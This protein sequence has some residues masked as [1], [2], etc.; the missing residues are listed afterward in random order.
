MNRAR[1][2]WSGLN[3]ILGVNR[4][5]GIYKKLKRFTLTSGM[6]GDY[7]HTEDRLSE[8]YLFYLFFVV[9]FLNLVL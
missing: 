6:F 5:K 2:F 7:C 4:V 1:S 8:L 9:V 3:S